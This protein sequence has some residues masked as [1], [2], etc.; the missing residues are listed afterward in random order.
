MRISRILCTHMQSVHSISSS[1]ECIWWRRA[2]GPLEPPHTIDHRKQHQLALRLVR[3][4][5]L[6]PGLAPLT[7]NHIVHLS[8]EACNRWGRSPSICLCS[9]SVSPWQ[10]SYMNS[11]GESDI[12][13]TNRRSPVACSVPVL[14]DDPRGQFL[15]SSV[16]VNS[17][18][19]DHARP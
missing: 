8:F 2:Q 6:L 5:C 16:A 14:P 18:T 19:M 15:S 7:A 9:H 11:C 10:L 3:S 13:R 1:T 17:L 4:W 12:L